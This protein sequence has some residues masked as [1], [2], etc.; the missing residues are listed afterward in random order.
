VIGGWGED[1]ARPVSGGVGVPGVSS[2]TRRGPNPAYV[3][4]GVCQSVRV[5]S[6]LVVRAAL[7]GLREERR[8]G[9]PQSQT[10][11]E[12]NDSV[13]SRSECAHYSFQSGVCWG[14]VSR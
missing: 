8:R 2:P 9:F 12:V 5:L 1:A 4:D 3:Y 13:W 11:W 14:V 10:G 7:S 6:H